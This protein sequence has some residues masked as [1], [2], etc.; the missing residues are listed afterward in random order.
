M[1]STELKRFD[2]RQVVVTLRNGTKRLGRLHA[3][4]VVGLYHIMR[5]PA[6][7]D[8]LAPSLDVRAED[9]VDVTPIR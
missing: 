8:R 6:R 5:D 3:T 7:S 9:V 2:N 1:E 4:D